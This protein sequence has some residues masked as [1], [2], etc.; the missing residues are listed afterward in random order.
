MRFTR[1]SRAAA[2]ALCSFAA[3]LVPTTAHAVPA[4]HLLRHAPGDTLTLPVRGALQ[5][6]VV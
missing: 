2:A 4:G 1:D 5:G 3:L 6:L